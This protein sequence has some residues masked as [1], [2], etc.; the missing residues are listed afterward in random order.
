MALTLYAALVLQSYVLVLL[1]TTLQIGA[2]GWYLLSYIPGGAPIL[3]GLTRAGVRICSAV[4]CRSASTGGSGWF[5]SSNYS[6][7]PL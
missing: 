5:S 4:C 6:L 7:L 2:L 3:R 1:F